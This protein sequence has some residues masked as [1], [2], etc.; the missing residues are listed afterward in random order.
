MQ[1]QGTLAEW[2]EGELS[3]IVGVLNDS[4]TK[5]VYSVI[6]LDFENK[7]ASYPMSVLNNDKYECSHI[8]RKEIFERVHVNQLRFVSAATKAWKSR[9]SRQVGGMASHS[10]LLFIVTGIFNLSVIFSSLVNFKGNRSS[11]QNIH[12]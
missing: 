5:S 8:C 1:T 9:T 11:N 6:I 3:E 2:W 12:L 10:M 4:A 7:S